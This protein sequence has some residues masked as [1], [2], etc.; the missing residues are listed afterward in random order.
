M[1]WL[2]Q[3]SNLSLGGPITE[4]ETVSVTK[5]LDQNG[6]AFLGFEVPTQAAFFGAKSLFAAKDLATHCE[7]E[8]CKARFGN[9]PP[10]SHCT[11]GRRTSCDGLHLKVTLLSQPEL[12][13]LA[14]GSTFK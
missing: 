4:I 11:V 14:S 5:Y 10:V 9:R 1:S 12:M 3:L 8:P 2:T 13:T 6:T 7:R